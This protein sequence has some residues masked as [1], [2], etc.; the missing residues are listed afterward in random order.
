MDFTASTHENGFFG[1]FQRFAFLKGPSER[2]IPV[3]VKGPALS[4]PSPPNGTSPQATPSIIP[5][6]APKVDDATAIRD[7]W[8]RSRR[9]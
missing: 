9:S 4:D 5:E 2:T 8:T 1:L 3:H 6:S 7:K